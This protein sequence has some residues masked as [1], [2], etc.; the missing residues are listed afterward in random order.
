MRIEGDSGVLVIDQA[1]VD[2]GSATFHGGRHHYVP[3]RTS[4]T[5]NG[6][7]IDEERANALIE[8]WNA[9]RRTSAS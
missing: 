7:P 3:G 9:T 4:Y 5:L 8:E 1:Q 6:E 2:V